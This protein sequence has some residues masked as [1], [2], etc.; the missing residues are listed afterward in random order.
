MEMFKLTKLGKIRAKM[1][2][3]GMN[4]EQVEE[5]LSSVQEMLFDRDFDWRVRIKRMVDEI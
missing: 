2:D 5:I 4:E 3:F 1:T